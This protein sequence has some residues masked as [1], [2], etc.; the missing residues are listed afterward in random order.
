MVQTAKMT[1]T[2][3][4]DIAV[5][6]VV[7]PEKRGPMKSNKPIPV[8]KERNKAPCLSVVNFGPPFSF[9]IYFFEKNDS[10]DGFTHGIYK[11]IYGDGPS[12]TMFDRANFVS[13]LARR[14]P[15][16][17]DEV[18]KNGENNYERRLFLRYP[19]QLVSTAQTRQDGLNAMRDFLMDSRF[20]RYP[21]SLIEVRDLTDHAESE[22]PQ[23]MDNF[24]MNADIK[25]AVIQ[26]L[27][28]ID[29][30]D[31]FKINFPKESR[32]MW[33]SSHV[34]EFGTSLGF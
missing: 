26:E 3:R 22:V 33:Q 17:D 13:Q 32:Y 15:G 2:K 8:K 34:G 18:M 23:S 14:I 11:Q 30:D 21:P 25:A 5:K 19:P 4:A 7:T 20:S 27:S 28:E 9:E 16:S 6:K 1:P 24:M 12:H 31:D 29:L 10:N